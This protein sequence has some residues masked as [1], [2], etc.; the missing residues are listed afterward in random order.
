MIESGEPLLRELNT[1][2][3]GRPLALGAVLEDAVNSKALVPLK[4]FLEKKESL[5]HKSWIPTPWQ[6]VSW[7]LRQLGVIGGAS[8]EDKLVK[9][10]FVVVANV[11][12]AA[13]AVV[14]K[15]NKTATSDAERIF[16]RKLFDTTFSETLGVSTL[17]PND[18]NV[19]I[20]HLSRDRD[21]IVYDPTSGVIKFAASGQQHATPITKE[22]I[23]IASLRSLISSLQPQIDHL[24]T[25]IHT[26]DI[27]ARSAVTEKHLLQAKTALRQKK[28]ATTK[29]E[30]RTATLAQLEDVYAKI[31]QAADQVQI[32]RVLEQSG[33]ALKALNQ[34][35]GGV[36]KVQDVMEGL[37][38]DMMDTEEIGNAISEVAMGEVDEGEVE[39]ELEALE[40]V[41]RE[42]VEAKERAER[43]K[44][45][46]VER[47]EA[48]K[49]EAEEA[50]K[51]RLRLAELDAIAQKE[52]E[53]KETEAQKEAN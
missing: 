41:E 1:Q 28:A 11:E 30:Q 32:V 44:R 14:E 8:S 29:L 25:Q 16:S 47:E 51:T 22:D 15:A 2:E 46:Q 52:P 6:V 20:T 45:E 17:S 9:G 34:K 23:S 19:L 31:E 35:T 48:M 49:R 53:S 39:D 24:T 37:R 13:K 18:M 21:A 3:Y 4:D 12:A 7:G 40:S 43:E 5:Y 27:R 42:K 38:N 36:E 50:E 33:Q 10:S 26:L